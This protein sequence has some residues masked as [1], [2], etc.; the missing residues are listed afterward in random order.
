VD[1]I[2]RDE[3]SNKADAKI[4]S[5][6]HLAFSREDANKKVY[7]QDLVKENAAKL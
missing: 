4:I 5:D 2:Y 6:L 7:V 3:I 1:F